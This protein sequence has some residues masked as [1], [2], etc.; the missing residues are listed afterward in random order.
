MR[1]VSLFMDW[2]KQPWDMKMA[3]VEASVLEDIWENH[4]L[5]SKDCSQRG[6]KCGFFFGNKMGWN[7]WIIYK[8]KS[9]LGKNLLYQYY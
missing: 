1:Y 3:I 8:L 5:Q 4:K 2:G 7:K 6:A 9:A